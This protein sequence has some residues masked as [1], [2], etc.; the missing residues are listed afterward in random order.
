MSS[1]PKAKFTAAEL[2][3]GRSYRVVKEFLDYDGIPHSPDESW[4]FIEKN[5]LPYEDGLT[6]V[7]E[8]DGQNVQFRLQWRPDAQGQI[9][10]EF[11][12]FVEEQ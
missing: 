11:S 2:V 9:I 7:V 6:L 12:S 5:F 4:R 3:A 10:D 8:R 1:S